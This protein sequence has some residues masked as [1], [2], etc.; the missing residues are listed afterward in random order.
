MVA[1]RQNISELKTSTEAMTPAAG[2]PTEVT[3]AISPP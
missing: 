2:D 1:P 3:A